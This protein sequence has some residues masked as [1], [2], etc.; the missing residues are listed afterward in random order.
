MQAS[1]EIVWIV[2]EQSEAGEWL[3]GVFT[4]LERARERVAAIGGDRLADFRIEGHGLDDPVATFR[5][6]VVELARDGAHL[7]TRVFIGCS[8]CG[9][10]PAQ[11]ERQCYIAPGGEWMSVVVFAA[12]PGQAL[13]AAREHH[14]R[15]HDQGRWS[16]NGTR[17]APLSASA[18]LL[19]ADAPGQNDCSPASVT[20]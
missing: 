7:G 17:L 2:T 1:G 14:A 6:W 20:T 19:R 9:D 12:T 11:Y 4:S 8:S 3:V 18:E 5:P 16:D 15:L 13:A 10:D